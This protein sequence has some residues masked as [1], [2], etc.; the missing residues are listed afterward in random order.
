[1]PSTECCIRLYAGVNRVDDAQRLVHAEAHETCMVSC[2][3]VVIKT[4]ARNA[5]DCNC[6]SKVAVDT[7]NEVV[8]AAHNRLAGTCCGVPPVANVF[9]AVAV[10]VW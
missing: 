4:S 6:D 9:W 10:T 5:R 3:A 1:M 8:L 2:I 7:N